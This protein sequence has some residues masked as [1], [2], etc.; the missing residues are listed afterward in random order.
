VDL[1]LQGRAVIVTGGSNGIGAAIA[2]AYGAEGADVAVAY[3]QNRDAAEE[4]AAEA[5]KGGG[6]AIT[7][8]HDLADPASAEALAA[9]ALAEF[10]RIDVLVNNAVNWGSARPNFN[11]HSEEVPAEEWLPVV[12]DNLE[13]TMHATRAVLPAMRAR[14]WGRLVHISSDLA[15]NGMPGS[16]YYPAAKAAM[17]GMNRSLA[18]ELGPVGILTNVV[19]PGATLTDRMMAALPQEMRDHAVTLTPAGRLNTPE[20]VAATVVFLGS[21]ANAAITGEAI[22]ASGGR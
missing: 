6:R 17:H 22:K 20:E 9:T 21:A 13:G 12:R 8:H 10:G 18:W 14:G 16:V 2:R 7:V 4:V 19:M 5:G 15:V 11:R 3:H 1:G